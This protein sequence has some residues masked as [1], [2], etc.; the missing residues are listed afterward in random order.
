MSVAVIPIAESHVDGFHACLDAVARES[1]ASNAAQFVAVD[2]ALV[3]VGA[4]SFLPGHTQSSIAALSAWACC[5]LIG[6]RVL[7]ET[8]WR[9]ACPR[10]DQTA[11]RALLVPDDA[12]PFLA[13]EGIVFTAEGSPTYQQNGSAFRGSPAAAF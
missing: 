10:L 12:L 1:V 5:P 13:M 11:S 7:V 4:T 6:A 9:S 2:G 3:V 8:S